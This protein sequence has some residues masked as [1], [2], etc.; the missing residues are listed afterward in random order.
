MVGGESSGGCCC[1]SVISSGSW[2]IFF[3]LPFH[4]RMCIHSQGNGYKMIPGDLAI[5]SN[6]QCK[7]GRNGGKGIILKH[8]F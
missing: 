4:F 7:I 5:T 8:A 3:L 6:F 2:H 1:R